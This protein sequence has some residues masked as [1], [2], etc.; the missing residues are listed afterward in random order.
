MGQEERSCM[1]FVRRPAAKLGTSQRRLTANRSRR[2]CSVRPFL[3]VG[4]IWHLPIRQAFIF[5]RLMAEKHSPF[6][7]RRGSLA[8]R[9]A[10]F[11]TII[12]SLYLLSNEVTSQRQVSLPRGICSSY[13]SPSKPSSAPPEENTQLPNCV[14]KPQL[15]LRFS[16]VEM[17]CNFTPG[18][19]VL[20]SSPDLAG[21]LIH[22]SHG[23]LNLNRLLKDSVYLR[24]MRLPQAAEVTV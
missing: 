20:P 7:Y 1:H 8:I 19:S 21:P 17:V 23:F 16:Q 14:A 5:A 18:V 2:R 15:C 22:P 13:C 24:M 10:G 6:R 4:S 9:R 3:R 11:R 12:I